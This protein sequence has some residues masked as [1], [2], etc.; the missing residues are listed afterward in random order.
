MR[1][2][3]GI[4]KTEINVVGLFNFN[5]GYIKSDFVAS[6]RVGTANGDSKK[7]NKINE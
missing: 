5:L 7:G 4:D 1:C 6:G 3:R 2:A